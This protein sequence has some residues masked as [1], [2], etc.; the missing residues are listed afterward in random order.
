MTNNLTKMT[1]IEA[2][3]LVLIV[4]IN[5]IILNLPQTIL[6]SCGSS[7]ILN[8]IYVSAIVIIFTFIIIK[9][10]KNFSSSDIVDISEFIGGKFLKVIIGFLIS[11]YLILISS[12]SIRNFC[13]VLHITYY[14]NASIK[15]LLLFFVFIC[16]VANF[17]GEQ[18]II[19]TNVIVTFIMI[20]SLFITFLS[21][22]PNF[23]IERIFP[24]LGYGS[25][26]TF[27]SGLSNI[28]SFNG[29]ICIYCIMP[30]LANKNDFKKITIVSIILISILLFLATA[31]L[32]LSLA[33]S[34]D[35]ENISPIY[36][37]ISNN[38]FGNFIQHPE[39]LFV[40]TWILSVISYLDIVVMLVIRLLKK[41]SGLPNEKLF[42]IP[43]CIIIY[44]I[45]LIPKNILETHNIENFL[46]K[47]LLFPITFVILPTILIIANIKYKKQNKI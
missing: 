41:V 43:I 2:I 31:C 8:V 13:E 47:F 21:V 32:L 30:M 39:S 29:L 6:N 34:S 22:T 9:L 36:T 5:R 20:L 37:L 4:T 15:Y 46:Y 11:I 19:R 10:Y 12:I 45:A 3:C 17:L 18:S 7:S 40:F 24:V 23:V 26:Q 33:Y 42:I 38:E 16:I 35:I 1:S 44:I 25:Y 14:F 27:F 28:F